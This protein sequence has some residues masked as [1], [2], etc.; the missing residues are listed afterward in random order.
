MRVAMYMVVVV[1]VR[2]R[3]PGAIRVHMLVNVRIM[4][5][6]VVPMCGMGLVVT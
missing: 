6:H 5:R 2:M 4:V 3:M 1:S